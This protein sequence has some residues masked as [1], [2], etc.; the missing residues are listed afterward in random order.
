MQ[1]HIWHSFFT[2]LQV[3]FYKKVQIEWTLLK[4]CLHRIKWITIIMVIL[5]HITIITLC[6]SKW[7][8]V[9]ICAPMWGRRKISLCYKSSPSLHFLWILSSSWLWSASTVHSIKMCVK[10]DSADFDVLEDQPLKNLFCFPSF[11]AKPTYN[12]YTHNCNQ[13]STKCK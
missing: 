11:V 4:T 10:R 12:N 6:S 3:I 7:S 5:L 8:I 13:P 9:Y 2:F 1:S